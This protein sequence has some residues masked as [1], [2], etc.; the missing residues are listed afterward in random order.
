M[1]PRQYRL[2]L[3]NDIK[4]VYKGG[5]RSF[6]PLFR[7]LALPTTNPIWRATVVVS[8]KVSGKAVERNT[9]KR[10]LRAILWQRR[11]QLKPGYDLIIVAQSAAVT[12]TT[13]QLNEAFDVVSKKL[14]IYLP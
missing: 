6:H 14:N 13:N 4:S 12:A 5:K 2:R 11:L 9:V 10:R 3:T 8:T 7:L 1:L